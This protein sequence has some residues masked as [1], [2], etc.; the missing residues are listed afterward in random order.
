MRKLEQFIIALCTVPSVIFWS[1]PAISDDLVPK[2]ADQ[3]VFDVDLTGPTV[4]I[5]KKWLQR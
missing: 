4:V 5:P 2:K 3:I 1:L